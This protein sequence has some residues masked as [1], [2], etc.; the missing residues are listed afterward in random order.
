MLPA[1]RQETLTGGGSDTLTGRREALV[2]VVLA[3]LLGAGL[4]FFRLPGAELSADEAASWAAAS[5]PDLQTLIERQRVLDPGKLAL[6]DAALHGWILI[7]GDSPG[8]MRALPASLGILAIAL[9][10][11]VT[12]ALMLHFAGTDAAHA[13]V[14]GA[15]AA[16]ICALNLTLIDQSRTLRMYPL[17]LSLELAQTL[18]FIRAVSFRPRALDRSA[19]LAGTAVFGALAIASNFTALFL[20]AAEALW[21]ILLAIRHWRSPSPSYFHFWAPAIAL[22]AGVALLAPIAPSAASNSVA[23]VNAGVLNWSHLRPLWWPLE[24]LRSAS[25]KA[26]FLIMLPLALYAGWQ[27]SRSGGAVALGFALCWI[28]APIAI[29]MAIS[30]AF[31]PFEETRYVI[32]S[33]AA[34]LILAGIGLAAIFDRTARFAMIAL[35]LAFS[36]DHV[37]RDFAKPEFVQWREAAAI[38]VTA[39]APD[40]TIAVV[41]AYAVQVVRYYTP[42]AQRAR[43][44]AFAGNC[45]PRQRALLVSGKETL[46]PAQLDAIR[47]CAPISVK[48]LR[49]V[50]VRKR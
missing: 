47:N 44:A 50:E 28:F 21:L 43:I 13:E 34:F 5:A 10:F 22:C 25:G 38:A 24:L 6:Y 1:A 9:V 32:S 7:G 11:A 23:V 49:L 41:P 16:L 39:S 26:P 4:R 15:M 18:C 27:L 12:R 42:L 48:T 17:T 45:D 31:I 35:V 3:V 20:I 14:A 33:F 46:S 37:R 40:D 36:L 8:W 30:Y 29:V 2:L 19:M